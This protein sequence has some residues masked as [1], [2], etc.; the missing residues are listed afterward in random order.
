MKKRLFACVVALSLTFGGTAL[1]CS[2]A[3]NKPFTVS[4]V[5][6]L[7]VD[8]DYGLTYTVLDDGTVKIDGVSADDLPG[9]FC[10]PENIDG[11]DVTV[12]G[13]DAFSG[14][15]S[16]INVLIPESVTVIEDGAFRDCVNLTRFL[17]G[18]TQVEYGADV[19]AGCFNLRMECIEE[20]TAHDYAVQNGIEYVLYSPENNY[21][22]G[23]MVL[24][25]GTVKITEYF[26]YDEEIVIPSEI[27]GKAVTVI[28]ECAFW[29]S[30][31]LSVEIPEGVKRIEDSAFI[32][33]LDLEEIILPES[34][35]YVG[36]YA[37]S[38]TLWAQNEAEAAIEE[39]GYPFIIINGILADAQACSAY[40]FEDGSPITEVI[41]PDG[42]TSINT[43]AFSGCENI[44]SVIVPNG[45][46]SIGEYAFSGC[47]ALKEILIPESVTEI[48]NSAFY[49]SD[50]VTIYCY[51]DSAAL[52][53]AQ[54]ND[55]PYVILDEDDSVPDSNP[56][57]NPDST[58]DSTPDSVPDSAPDTS[59][60]A[61]SLVN[62]ASN[63]QTKTT[64]TTTTTTS[65]TSPAT[66][67]AASG[68]AVMALGA[69]AV[70]V[71]KNKRK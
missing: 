36:P 12:I 17:A 5:T 55:I 6:S 13:E 49:G 56:D 9:D 21:D 24:D 57:S 10:I 71:V 68:L 16:I 44:E 59:S 45:V 29:E 30:Y 65:D 38:G 51:S 69:A 2:A 64:T 23:Y 58:P 31:L 15:K 70:A 62:T 7:E 18:E 67:T 42:V 34:L 47:T 1:T 43:N 27:N 53:F 26:G 19:F 52:A 37:F 33:S 39:C 3:E 46:V 4:G 63:V 32:D 41:I 48:S 25:D 61:D 20:S 14:L 60:T 22:Y 50:G 40:V 35:E 11:K 28:G 66:G 54:E 8:E